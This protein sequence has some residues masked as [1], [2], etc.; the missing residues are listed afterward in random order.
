[1]LRYAKEV[2]IFFIIAIFIIGLFSHYAYAGEG[3][4]TPVGNDCS[5]NNCRANGY[6]IACGHECCS[7]GQVCCNTGCYTGSCPPSCDYSP[8]CTLNGQTCGNCGVYSGC[9]TACDGGCTGCICSNDK[10]ANGDACTSSSDCC[11]GICIKG[12]CLPAEPDT[13]Q[14]S[15]EMINGTWLGAVTAGSNGPCCGDDG[16]E[17][18]ESAGA[19]KGACYNGEYYQHNQATSDGKYLIFNGE[20]NYCEQSA[21]ETFHNSGCDSIN[22]GFLSRFRVFLPS[23]GFSFALPWYSCDHIGNWYC[24]R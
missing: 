1:M 14:T 11:S 23:P 19:G 13:D 7:Y 17:T 10:K 4:Y 20:L 24:S 2:A 8:K 6:Y 9:S 22:R 12:K 5:Y 21:W 3:C 16:S 15:C 18:F